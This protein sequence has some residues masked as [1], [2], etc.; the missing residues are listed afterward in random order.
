MESPSAFNM[1]SAKV[2]ILFNGDHRRLWSIVADTL[3]EMI[4]P[5]NMEQ[6]QAKLDMF[7]AAAGSILFFEDESIV[8]SYKKQFALYASAF[9]MFAAHGIGILQGNV[10][11]A[12]ADKGI[13]ANLQHYNPLI[14]AAVAKEWDIP[15]SHRLVSQMVFG[16]IVNH[17]DPKEKKPAGERVRI[18]E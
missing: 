16:G 10:W 14:D 1:Q 15:A 7:S 2:L 6:T 11:N 3:R 8:D 4:P 17:P 13:G 9:D 5:E 12:L 18:I